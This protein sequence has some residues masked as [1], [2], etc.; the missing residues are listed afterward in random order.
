MSA[1]DAAKTLSDLSRSEMSSYEVVNCYS[2]SAAT[3]EQ[4]LVKLFIYIRELSSKSVVLGNDYVFIIVQLHLTLKNTHA[5]MFFQPLTLEHTHAHL[6]TN[7]HMPTYTHTHSRTCTRTRTHKHTSSS[8]LASVQKREG[9]ISPH[10]SH[11]KIISVVL[12]K[13]DTD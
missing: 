10:L 7:T 3:Y 9:P 4:V 13:H 2:A 8:E 12:D 1:E 11:Y 6:H 5:F